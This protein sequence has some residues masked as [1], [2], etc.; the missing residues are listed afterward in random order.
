MT[1]CFFNPV[2]VRPSIWAVLV[3]AV[4]IVVDYSRSRMLQRV[5]T[6]HR[7]QAL[8]ADALHFSTDM[9]SSLVVLA[10]LCLLF[11]ADFLPETSAVRPRLE[12]ADAVAALGVSSIIH[13]ISWSLGKRA[14]NVLLDA[15][16]AALT[17]KIITAL[18]PLEGI[19]KIGSVRLRHSRPDL[20]IDLELAVDRTTVLEEIDHIRTVV[21]NAVHGVVEYATVNSVF[22]PHETE[23][24]D[25]IAR[26]RG[27]A[28]AH[29]LTTHAVD[30]L[31][32]E[33]A[34]SGE[35]HTLVEMHVEFPPQTSLEEAFHKVNV[36]EREFVKTRPGTVM[37]THIEPSGGTGIE[38]LVSLVESSDVMRTVS[39]IVKEE[40][41]IRDAHNILLRSFCDGRRIS[42][43]CA[44]DHAATVAE[45]HHAATR[46]QERIRK[47]LPA[48]ERVTVQIEPC[49]ETDQGT[50]R[51]DDT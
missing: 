35:G 5:A 47:E 48:L 17:G 27:L 37:V 22:L 4:S 34:G 32:L 40:P 9:L 21:E 31:D 14:V 39:H 44:M 30:V 1:G 51:P 45:A 25:R 8:E 3:M 2:A 42:F 7:S 26:L 19:R 15:G 6:K 23:Q 16:D 29:G 28:A 50:T 24:G 36:F 18:L 33:D 43:H 10:G 12:K 20:F 49:S 41:G 13:S 46:V 11:L 38:R